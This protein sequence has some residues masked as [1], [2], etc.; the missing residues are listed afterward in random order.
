M[1]RV[2]NITHISASTNTVHFMGVPGQATYLP[3]AS[4]VLKVGTGDPTGHGMHGLSAALY[5]L[6][7][8][9]PGSAEMCAAYYGNDAVWSALKA[10]VEM[11]R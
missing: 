10:N 3:G 7:Q 2:T 4:F 9:E 8:R 1:R 11:V 5:S 6:S